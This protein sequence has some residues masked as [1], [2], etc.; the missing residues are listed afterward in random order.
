MPTGF[1]TAHLPKT[2]RNLSEYEKK[3]LGKENATNSLRGT[4]DFRGTMS[5][6][7]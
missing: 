2:T 4:G 3:Q 7:W 6:Q 5:Y 1:Q